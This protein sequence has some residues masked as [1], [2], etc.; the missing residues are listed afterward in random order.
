MGKWFLFLLL[1]ACNAP[2]PHFRDQP[3]T[4][5]QVEG[6]LFDVRVRG[7][8]AEAIRVNPQYAPRL[9]PISGLAA[10]AMSRVSG[11]DVTGVLGD[12]ALMTGVLSCDEHPDTRISRPGPMR[13]DCL[14]LQSWVETQD[15][16]QYYDF[17]CDPY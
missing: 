13:F 12:Q 3:V 15:G 8:L 16:R 10:F 2:S 14:E 6:S 5:V 17:D 11:C 4:R 7:N 1:A 9:G